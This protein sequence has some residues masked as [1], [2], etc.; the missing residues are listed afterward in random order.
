MTRVRSRGL[1]RSA[2]AAVAGRH[3]P[4]PMG[5]ADMPTQFYCWPGRL[6]VMGPTHQIAP[7]H[8]M[9]VQIAI[10]VD[11]PFRLRVPPAAWRSLRG[12][13]WDGTRVHEVDAEGGMLACLLV[14][15]ESA[16]GTALRE[17]LPDGYVCELTDARATAC[18][19]PLERLCTSPSVALAERVFEDVLRALGVEAI[20][21]TVDKRVRRAADRLRALPV[22][23]ISVADLARGQGLSERRMIDLYKRELGIPV[24]R[25]LLWL[26]LIDALKLGA[27]GRG[28]TDAAHEAGFSDSAHLNRTCL[29]ML[30]VRPA[31]LFASNSVKLFAAGTD[32]PSEISWSASTRSAK[33]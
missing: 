9:A 20:H 32:R 5:T 27:S 15:P 2:V 21:P 18:R 8:H 24:R 30:G 12:G 6:L 17:R 13:F 1:S 3:H 11:G 31:T 26:R 16:V 19:S 25:Y 23:R 33:P 22:K 4:T 7:H 14:E 28:I 10:G 29:R